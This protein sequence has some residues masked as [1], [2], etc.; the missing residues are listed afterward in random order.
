MEAASAGHVDVTCTWL[1]A[2]TC[3]NK[4]SNEFKES[5]LTLA[6]Y[7]GNLSSRCVT[8]TFVVILR[9]MLECSVVKKCDKAAKQ[10][11]AGLLCIVYICYFPARW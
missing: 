10:L 8:N 1:K 3:I 11:V 2:G 5:A 6:C 4:H 7:K 9:V